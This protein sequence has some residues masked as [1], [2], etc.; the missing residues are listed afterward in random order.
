M[1]SALRSAQIILTTR[2]K[3]KYSLR[4]DGNDRRT[5]VGKSSD[6]FGV[7]W[8]H[9]SAGH[10][11]YQDH[12]FT[13]NGNEGGANLPKCGSVRRIERKERN[14][15]RTVGGAQGQNGNYKRSPGQTVC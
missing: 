11:K 13:G 7:T 14:R 8:G 3:S 9:N 10:Q 12:L 4:N 6:A 1:E 15:T 5:E 2:P